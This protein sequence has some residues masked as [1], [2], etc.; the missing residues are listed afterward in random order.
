M[1]EADLI[2]IFG[3]LGPTLSVGE[4]ARSAESARYL[5]YYSIAPRI[6][7]GW[8]ALVRVQYS[9][10][11]LTNKLEKQKNEAQTNCYY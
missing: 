7:P 9:F 11:Q 1:A 3:V 2:T 6:P 5:Q 8:K 10:G 4:L